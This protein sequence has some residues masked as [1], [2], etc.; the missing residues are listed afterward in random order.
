[1]FLSSVQSKISGVGG[2]GGVGNAG[3]PSG[4]PEFRS[5][6]SGVQKKTCAYMLS[7]RCFVLVF[8]P[9]AVDLF[10]WGEGGIC[11]R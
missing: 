11:V 7:W 9:L 1:M 3:V 4:V 5:T 2:G 6:S 8:F 10:S